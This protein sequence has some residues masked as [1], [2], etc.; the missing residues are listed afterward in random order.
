MKQV[1]D[2]QCN[3]ETSTSFVVDLNDIMSKHN[4]MLCYK[5]NFNQNMIRSILSMT[6]RKMNSSEEDVIVKKKVFNV[7][8]ECLQNISKSSMVMEGEQSLLMIGKSESD[9]EI[10][11]GNVIAM[12]KKNELEEILSSI[13]SSGKDELKRLHK[14]LMIDD[15][16]FD[17]NSIE[18]ALIDIARRTGNKIKYEF[19]D[20]SDNRCFFSLKTTIS[21]NN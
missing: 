16:F 9:Y 1:L 19:K 10:Y 21:K 8:V 11:S 14:L 13:S 5:G 6:E 4:F 3:F 2:L 7:L 12:E 15:A 18:V 20:I 17:A